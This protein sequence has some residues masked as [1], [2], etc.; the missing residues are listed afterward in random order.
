MGDKKDI[1]KLFASGLKDFEANPPQNAWDS[2]IADVDQKKKA[3]RALIWRWAAVAAAL[4]LAFYAGYYFNDNQSNYPQ[5]DYTNNNPEIE[6]NKVPEKTASEGESNKDEVV[7]KPTSQEPETVADNP[8]EKRKIQNRPSQKNDGMASVSTGENRNSTST[9]ENQASRSEDFFSDPLVNLPSSSLPKYEVDE[10]FPELDQELMVA[11]TY[12]EFTDLK[13]ISPSKPS[14][15][16]RY[17][18]GIMASPTFPFIENRV[19]TSDEATT[20]NINKAKPEESYAVGISLGYR[21]SKR[22]QINSGLSLN[23]WKQSSTDLLLSISLSSSGVATNTSFQAKGYTN[24]TQLNFDGFSDPSNQG[25]FETSEWNSLAGNYAVL[26]SLSEE[27]RFIDIPLSLSYYIIDRPKWNFAVTGGINSRIL[28]RINATI[29]Y[30]DGTSEPYK[31]IK[32]QQYTSQLIAG[33]GLGYNINRRLQF[34]VRPTLLY[35]ISKVNTHPQTDTYFHQILI[36]SGL[37]FRF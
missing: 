24:S 36:Y 25:Q 2:I 22:L 5:T 31:E 35:G 23:H 15:P 32:L 14:K 26:P 4:I 17:S 28:N 20:K 11:I 6:R 19:Q 29:T 7:N 10:V 16:L 8:S 12:E 33:F 37:S 9:N 27:Y 30:A 18:V 34:S 3:K 21:L 13:Q 1:D